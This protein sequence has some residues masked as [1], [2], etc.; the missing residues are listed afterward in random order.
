[1][2]DLIERSDQSIKWFSI[3]ETSLDRLYVEVPE[4]DKIERNGMFGQCS[5]GLP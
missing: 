2:G 4:S 3:L 1:M 5:F